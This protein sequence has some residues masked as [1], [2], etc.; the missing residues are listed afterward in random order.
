MSMCSIAA[1]A[2]G[3][4]AQRRDAF[5]CNVQVIMTQLP[6]MDQDTLRCLEEEESRLALELEGLQLQYAA[7]HQN[8]CL[9][10][11]QL[12][13]QQVLLH[14]LTGRRQVTAQAYV[15]GPLQ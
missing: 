5:L 4:N 13:T 15:T 14:A 1:T 2:H 11:K 7:L 6:A 8:T 10:E 3:H 9:M 12:E